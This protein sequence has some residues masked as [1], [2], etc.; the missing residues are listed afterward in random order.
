MRK[1]RS[2]VLAACLGALLGGGLVF[3]LISAKGPS[4]EQADWRDR[5]KPDGWD[6]AW[7]I[8]TLRHYLKERM[9]NDPDDPNWG[10]PRYRVDGQIE[11]IDDGGLLDD[12]CHILALANGQ[13]PLLGGPKYHA[14]YFV[15]PFRFPTGAF[16]TTDWDQAFRYA[17]LVGSK[18][19]DAAKA[20]RIARLYASVRTG[21]GPDGLD[22]VDPKGAENDLRPLR[23]K[24]FPPDRERGVGEFYEVSF[25]ALHN[26]SGGKVNE[27]RITLGQGHVSG[28]YRPVA[29]VPRIKL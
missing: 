4:I 28:M 2:V 12:R 8:R 24:A 3:A 21:H 5:P 1:F 18:S 22:V 25:T 6:E 16:V 10:E 17:L 20:E 13:R 15:G 11:V 23:V 19:I 9:P 7:A 27:W 14:V 29:R 26:D